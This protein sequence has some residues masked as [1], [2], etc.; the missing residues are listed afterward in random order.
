MATVRIPTP[1]RKLTQGLEEV[2]D[3]MPEP[4][5]PTFDAFEAWW[6]TQAPS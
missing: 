3:A 5:P 4:I 2:L 6:A 1:L